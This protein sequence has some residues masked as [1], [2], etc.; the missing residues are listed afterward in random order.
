MLKLRRTVCFPVT[1]QS[2]E[3]EGYLLETSRLYTEAFTA[4]VD[5]AWEMKRPS[6]VQ[7]H[8]AT[9]YTLRER[10]SLLSQLTITARMRAVEAVK[11]VR[12]RLKKG[13]RGSK[14]SA[15]KEVPM[16][17][18]GRTLTF[19]KARETATV[20]TQGGTIDLALTWHEQAER[21][22]EWEC[23]AG[24]IALT[25]TGWVLR[26]VFHKEV[27]AVERTGRVI[28][29]DR[30][31]R[32]SLVSSDNRFFGKRGWREHERKL[33]SLRAKLQRKGTK[34]AKRHLRVIRRRL[35]RFRRDCDRVLAKRLLSTVSPG[36][37]LVL[38]D[39]TDIRDRCGTK[40]NANKA[41]RKRMGR[42]SFSRLAQEIKSRAE[43]K[44]IHVEDVDAAYTSQTCSCYGVV[45][46]ANRKGALYQCRDCGF[47]C[48]ADLN[49]ARNIENMWR[50]ANGY[51]SR[52]S[53]N[54]PI[55][56]VCSHATYK[57]LSL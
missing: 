35:R 17:F 38:E 22:R 3:E 24:E 36:D 53:V 29:I 48:N 54:R 46:K 30:G 49:A 44:G 26:L 51:S 50:V 39:L 4:C 37:T 16:R 20:S 6:G 7:V 43:L 19:D 13:Q 41:H 47:R 15:H 33:L 56:G 2:L 32:H 5:V 11:A 57:P 9:Y 55:V 23:S 25:H 52:P 10:L 31:I 34:S 42:W 27:E 18:D 8:H 12:T 28:G 1:P 45:R 21:Y 40:G 14:P